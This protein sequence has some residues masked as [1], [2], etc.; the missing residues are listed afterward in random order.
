[1]IRF[2]VI[3]MRLEIKF[4]GAK[5]RESHLIEKYMEYEKYNKTIESII[6]ESNQRIKSLACATRR[7]LY[8]VGN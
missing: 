4:T 6:F 8:W 7:N 3:C 1:M 2:H 5:S